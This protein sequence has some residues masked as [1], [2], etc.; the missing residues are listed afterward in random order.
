MS[1]WYG[2]AAAGLAIAAGTMKRGS[3]AT[4]TAESVRIPAIWAFRDDPH[5]LV[6]LSGPFTG[7]GIPGLHD[8]AVLRL[9]RQFKHI[10]LEGPDNYTAIHI[11]SGYH[12]GYGLTKELA[13]G[14]SWILNRA[15]RKEGW[16]DKIDE[17]RYADLITH[18]LHNMD[19]NEVMAEYRKHAPKKAERWDSWMA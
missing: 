5:R 4:D 7:E 9:N 11:P 19:D 13:I 10:G 1:A 15:I 12:F 6:E 14:V 17:R 3:G 18:V 8:F 16:S 2:L